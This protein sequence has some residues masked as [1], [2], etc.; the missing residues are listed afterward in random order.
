MVLDHV[1]RPGDWA[2]R[3]FYAAGLQTGRPIDIDRHLIPI[4]HAAARPLRVA[5]A[6]DFH[7]G[8]TTSKKILKAA[9]AALESLDADVLL[10]GGDFVTVRAADIDDLAPLLAEVH[11]PLGKFAVLGNHDLR[12]NSTAL[13]KALGR[14]GVRML[15]NETVQLPPPYDHVTIAGLD[16]PIRGSPRG[17]ILDEASEVRIVLMHAP[18]GL[19]AIGD[20]D[21]DLALCGHTH[22]GQI[23]APGGVM[24]YLP[25]G[26]LSR[27]YP[28]GLFRL[29]PTGKR[30]MLVSRGVGC[31]TIP[32]RVGSPS[33]V[34]LFTLG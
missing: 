9:C 26:K 12:A 22:G 11:A 25:Y 5:F 33:Q 30:A 19:L 13:K 20:R 27:K 7:A 16:D 17:E 14:A 18:D 15:I 2:A 6:S 34:H 28:V 24:P 10:L 1:F 23:S 29:G 21:F 4:S 8:P 3:A 31:S 32:V